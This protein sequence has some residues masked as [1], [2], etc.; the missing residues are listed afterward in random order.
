MEPT[1]EEKALHEM[2]LEYLDCRYM[3]YDVMRKVR[4]IHKR[5]I[6]AEIVAFTDEMFEK[7]KQLS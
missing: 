5:K 4:L 6:M 1:P 3:E 7:Q 2:G